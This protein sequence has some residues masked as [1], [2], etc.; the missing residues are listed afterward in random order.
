[1]KKIMFSVILHPPDMDVY[2]VVNEYYSQFMYEKPIYL[3]YQN[4]IRA[5]G[6]TMSLLNFSNWLGSMGIKCVVKS[7]NKIP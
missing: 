7:V 3:S 2:K 1:M 5:K 6:D 4:E